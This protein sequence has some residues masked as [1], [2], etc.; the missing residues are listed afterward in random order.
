M[1]CQLLIQ[2]RK[3]EL[4]RTNLIL[5]FLL[6]STFSFG[7][8]GVSPTKVI[9]GFTYYEHT[10][11]PGNT[12]YGIQ[13]MYGV[14]MEEIQDANPG[15]TESLSEG[16]KILIPLGKEEKTIDYTVQ[17]KETLYGISR[18]FN[19]SVKKLKELNPILETAGLQKDQVIKVPAPQK[20]YAAIDPE[21]HQVKEEPKESFNPF[22]KEDSTKV[23]VKK[24]SFSDTTIVHTV[25]PHETLYSI[26]KRFMVSV[27][28]LMRVNKL[29]NSSISEGQKL[30]IPVQ[31]EEFS[32]VDVK[33]V[34]PFIEDAIDTVSAIPQKSEYGIALMMPFFVEHGPGYSQYISD[35]ATQFYMGALVAVD[36]LKKMGLN[37]K[38]YVYDTKNDTSRVKSLLRKPEFANVDLII[39]P[40]YGKPV[41][42]VAEYSKRTGTKMICPLNVDKSVL[43]HNP[44]VY[45]SVPSDVTL[46]NGLAK[47]LAVSDYDRVVL[48]RPSDKEGALVAESFKST[49]LNVAQNG[50]SPSISDADEVN[51]K[52]FVKKGSRVAFVYPSDEKVK[53]IKFMSRLNSAAILSKEDEVTIYGTK[54]WVNFE[55]INN[56]YKNKYN[57]HY[58]GPNYLDYYADELVEMNRNFRLRFNTD[59][60]KVSI[61]AYDLT[62]YFSCHFFGLNA[63][64]KALMNDF[65]PVQIDKGD[66]FENRSVFIVEQENFE[67]IK[68]AIVAK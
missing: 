45:A 47:H 24:R 51:F 68:K 32:N 44:N 34:D 18:K 5:I 11:A 33:S 26:S 1:A 43:R 64:C 30:I 49:Y 60:S 57:F 2:L 25:L 14:S 3:F 37:A 52:D 31:L 55:E 40:L 20:E 35:I 42:V 10:V 27:D 8:P 63:Q 54:D 53:V 38:L 28:E 29:P 36:S 56:V 16:Q 61:Q 21:K 46:F 62:T 9:D 48:I 39:G 59:L 17:N 15:L 67:L 6:V 66:G 65:N 58:P 19:T 41:P 13:R 50:T 23:E 7:Q 12:L 22:V 4:M